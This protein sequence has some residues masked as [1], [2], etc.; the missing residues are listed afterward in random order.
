MFRCCRQLWLTSRLACQIHCVI[1]LGSAAETAVNKHSYCPDSKQSWGHLGL[2]LLPRRRCRL[3]S[4]DCCFL[5][6]FNEILSWQV[7][8]PLDWEQQDDCQS[9]RDVL[10]ACASALRARNTE[11]CARSSEQCAIPVALLGFTYR[12]LFLLKSLLKQLEKEERGRWKPQQFVPLCKQFRFS[13]P[14]VQPMGVRRNTATSL[15]LLG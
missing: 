4:P 13:F 11:P 8:N 5:G 2:A 9:N 7:S 10:L 1:H 12:I 3:C 14:T 6:C 15:N